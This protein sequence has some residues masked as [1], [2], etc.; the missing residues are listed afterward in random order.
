MNQNGYLKIHDFEIINK[1]NYQELINQ[2]NICKQYD[3]S[4]TLYP[5]LRC[6]IYKLYINN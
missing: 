6:M 5:L 3:E 4:K 2:D 1:V